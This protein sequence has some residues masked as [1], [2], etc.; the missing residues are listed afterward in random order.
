[1]A[2][3]FDAASGS[4][5]DLARVRGSSKLTLPEKRQVAKSASTKARPISRHRLASSA[6]R[7]GR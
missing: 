3:S 1:M 5:R 6:V 2:A 7:G 4:S